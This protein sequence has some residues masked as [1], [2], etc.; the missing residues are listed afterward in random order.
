MLPLAGGYSRGK[1]GRPRGR[2]LCATAMAL[3]GAPRVQ[4]NHVLPSRRRDA[5]RHAASAQAPT[6]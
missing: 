5:S 1:R 4:C 6:A 3:P 2:G